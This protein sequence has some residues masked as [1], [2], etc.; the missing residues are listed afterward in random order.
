MGLITPEFILEQVSYS[1][2]EDVVQRQVNPGGV[3]IVSGLNTV[4]PTSMDSIYAG[5]LLVIGSE[6]ITIISTTAATFTAN[7]L[8]PHL[9]TDLIYGATF[10]S[11]QPD[12][13]NYT[14]AEM[15]GYLAEAQNVFLM[16]VRPIYAIQE[17]PVVVG[18]RIY[19]CPADSI[20]VERV[21]VN[22]VELWDAT[23]TDLDW[24]DS[25]WQVAPSLPRYW[26]QDKVGVQN[27]GVGPTPQ[28]GN[29][30]RIFYSQRGSPSIGLLDSLLVPDVMAYALKYGVLAYA[31]NKDGEQRDPSRAAYC[32]RRFDFI[33]M[34]A[35]KFMEGVQGRLRMPEETVEPLLS[36]M[37]G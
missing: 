2:I 3:D 12:H 16:R 23:Q 29:T 18:K 19:P 30:A 25:T 32:G 37:K 31:F 5:A 14:Q 28:V 1:L 11:G 9:S 26:Y 24:Q 4:T 27:F 34:L 21:S 7:F 20:R 22:A 13:P 15:L 36:A 35:K 10:P 8:S 33:T 6:V 17:I